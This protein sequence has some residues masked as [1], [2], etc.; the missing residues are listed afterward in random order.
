MS[1]LS[2]AFEDLKLAAENL[3]EW[4]AVRKVK[5]P[6]MLIFGLD[7]IQIKP[8]PYGVC[9]MICP[10]N[11]PIQ[12]TLVPLVGMIAAGNCVILKPSELAPAVEQLL[13]TKLPEYLDNDCF[14]VIT[15]SVKETQS[16][17]SQPQLNY[18]I[19]NSM[20][21]PSVRP[22]MFD[23]VFFTG[24]IN[25]GRIVM[26]A[27]GKHL[28]P[29]CLE[30][31]G[32]SP[33]IVDET[34]NLYMAARRICFGKF[35]NCSQSCIAPDYLL[36][37]ETVV[38]GLISE[39]TNVIHSMFGDN[40]QTS[41]SYGRIV[42]NRHFNRIKSMI[43]EHRDSE[44]VLGGKYDESDLYIEPTII[45]NVSADHP[46]MIEE[47]FGPIIPIKSYESLSECVEFINLRQKPLALYMFS[48]DNDN[49]EYIN[50][51]TSS[52]A[53]LCN[54]SLSHATC[55]SLPFG[56]V[57]TSGIGGYHGYHSFKT[58]SHFKPV[59]KKFKGLEF[60]NEPRLPPYT[61]KKF[62]QVKW[63]LGYPNSNK[64]QTGKSSLTSKLLWLSV[65]VSLGVSAFG[66]Y[67]RL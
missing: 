58:F 22:S 27:C 61:S 63:I 24:S 43:V 4:T 47:I 55:N 9:L 60:L 17:L 65:G 45:K 2:M 59:L 37:Q 53:F 8:E 41:D 11:Y 46:A 14:A 16:L 32:K 5:S 31:G 28:T 66:V 39:L 54:D 30:L 6:N 3:E 25:V 20:V 40:P 10:W 42:N 34:S 13:A 19:A 56:G 15:G 35:I 51:R 26:E 18:S 7:T 1:E 62:D 33:T 23:F 38:D 50:S 57:N 44:I 67:S 64:L 12:L 36:V 49:I 48:S 29:V 21:P 52:G